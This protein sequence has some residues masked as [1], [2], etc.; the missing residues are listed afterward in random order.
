MLA[1]LI[2]LKPGNTL[3]AIKNEAILY[4]RFKNTFDII[5]TAV[6]VPSCVASALC[7]LSH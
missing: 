3:L 4:Q 7:E 1:Y 6:H 2:L 5:I